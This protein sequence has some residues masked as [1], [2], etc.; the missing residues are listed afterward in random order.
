M[1]AKAY[2]E[3]YN[4][5]VEKDGVG[6]T[7]ATILFD[8]WKETQEIADHRRVST[9]EGW[10]GVFKEQEKKWKAFVREVDLSERMYCMYAFMVW[11]MIEEM[12]PHVQQ[13][14]RNRLTEL[15]FGLNPGD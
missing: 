4:A 10:V 9:D 15:G 7:L 14:V 13:P 12:P 1:K 8:M 5:T 11:N 6:E 2:A 3:K